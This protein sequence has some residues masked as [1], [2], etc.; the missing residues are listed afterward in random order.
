MATTNL[1]SFKATVRLAVPLRVHHRAI[2]VKPCSSFVAFS[3]VC[4]LIIC[5]CTFGSL[6]L[7]ICAPA[8]FPYSALGCFSAGNRLMAAVFFFSELAMRRVGVFRN[9]VVPR[10]ILRCGVCLIWVI[11]FGKKNGDMSVKVS[12]IHYARTYSCKFES[13]LGMGAWTRD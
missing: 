13:R 4:S 9:R 11:L 7:C 12:W 5:F 3:R 8:L 10:P 1:L 2:I 6:K